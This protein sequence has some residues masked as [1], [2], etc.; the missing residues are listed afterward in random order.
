MGNLTDHHRNGGESVHIGD[1]CVWA[2]INYLD[3]LTDY[4]ECRPQNSSKVSRTSPPNN[5]V[6]LE[7]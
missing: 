3:S 2:E 5:L 6:M 1:C 4:R 7:S